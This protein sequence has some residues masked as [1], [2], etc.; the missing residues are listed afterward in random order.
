MSHIPEASTRG[1]MKASAYDSHRPSYP[2]NSVDSL[3][4]YL[5]V[6]D[7][8]KARLLDLGAGTGKFTEILAQR[9]EAFEITAVEPHDAMREELQKKKLRR[10]QVLKGV[11][12]RIPAG[13]H[14][15]D[16]VIA[17]QV[18]FDRPC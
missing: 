9:D 11:A 13:D 14:A 6:K 4:Q 5:Q 2:T 8:N 17:A 7:L 1:F 18:R 3:L 16:A 10:V 12:S 15:F